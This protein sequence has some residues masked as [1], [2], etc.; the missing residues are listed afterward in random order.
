MLTLRQCI[1]GDDANLGDADDYNIYEELQ[2]DALSLGG[3]PGYVPRSEGDDKDSD[4]KEDDDSPVE[5]L[6]SAPSLVA[7]ISSGKNTRNLRDDPHN[8]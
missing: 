2:L 5:E 4:E 3:G 8:P 1:E 6:P 7:T